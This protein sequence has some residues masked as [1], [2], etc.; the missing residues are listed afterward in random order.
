MTAETFPNAAATSKYICVGLLVVATAEQATPSSTKLALRA[1]TSMM[2][3]SRNAHVLSLAD[4]KSLRVTNRAVGEYVALNGVAGTTVPLVCISATA[5]SAVETTG[6]RLAGGT[7]GAFSGARVGAFVKGE[8]LGCCVVG[9][10]VT[11]EN[12]DAR[13]GAAVGV[14][15]T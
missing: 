2:Y 14:C 6:A 4:A 15:G 8:K 3:R 5:G 11:G 1:N 9:T 12:V 7:V 10:G 13:M